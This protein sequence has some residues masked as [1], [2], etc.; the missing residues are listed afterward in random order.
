MPRNPNRRQQERPSRPGSN[1]PHDTTDQRHIEGESPPVKPQEA[2]VITRLHQARREVAALRG[3]V[4]ALMAQLADA[5]M[6]V[7][8]Q[9]RE[10]DRLRE[11][12]RG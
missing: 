8:S 3:D 10:I 2:S 9:G 4:K 11:V 5:R 6:L 1:Q 7:A 12:T